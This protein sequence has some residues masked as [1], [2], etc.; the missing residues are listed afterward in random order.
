MTAVEDAASRAQSLGAPSTVAGLAETP[1]PAELRLSCAGGQAE[2]ALAAEAEVVRARRCLA[3]QLD[4]HEASPPLAHSPEV[5]D[6]ADDDLAWDA[7]EW[8]T[9]PTKCPVLFRGTPARRR[10]TLASPDVGDLAACATAGSQSSAEAAQAASRS[11]LSRRSSTSEPATAFSD[12]VDAWS[13]ESWDSPNSV[14]KGLPSPCGSA[15]SLDRQMRKVADAVHAELRIDADALVQRAMSQMSSWISEEIAFARRGLQGQLEQ[16]SDLAD[17]GS[18]EKDA[19]KAQAG[20]LQAAF[21]TAVA[22]SRRMQAELSSRIERLESDLRQQSEDLQLILRAS[23]EAGQQPA[24]SFSVAEAR[25]L[26]E[27]RRWRLRLDALQEGIDKQVA[28]TQALDLRSSELALHISKHDAELR[29]CSGVAQKVNDQGQELRSALLLIRQIQ[30]ECENSKDAMANL[31]Q[32]VSV[33]A[34]KVLA[35][36]SAVQALE[37]DVASERRERLVEL[38]VVCEKVES[39]GEHAEKALAK[40]DMKISEISSQLAELL[41][42]EERLSSCMAQLAQLAEALDGRDMRFEGLR[43][44]LQQALASKACIND[45]RQATDRLNEWVEEVRQK[46]IDWSQQAHTATATEIEA[47]KATAA[48][49]GVTL[50][51]HSRTLDHLSCWCEQLRVR[52]QG[53]TRVLLHVLDSGSPEL[54]KLFERALTV[55]ELNSKQAA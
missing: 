38:R 19:F 16:L 29:K 37:A 22:E 9:S 11:S 14:L 15:R 40:R 3:G 49:Q 5:Y 2:A 31:G 55:P 53:L 8:R 48:A 7:E 46:I 39:Q 50:T 43:L 34:A 21:D 18:V 17:A 36:E 26:A 30:A 13:L 41:A 42:G 1:A 44:E 4:L 54:V 25:Q 20:E 6:M 32:G 23:T 12:E 51:R 33:A 52:E 28:S 45:L 10:R 47:T 35:V 24:K 27:E